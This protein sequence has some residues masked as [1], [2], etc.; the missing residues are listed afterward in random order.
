VRGLGLTVF[1]K[2]F[3]ERFFDVGIAEQ[4]AVTLA[5]GMACEGLKP[6]VA[7]YSSFLQRAYDQL[8]HDVCLQDLDVTFAVDRG[9]LVGADGATHAGSFDLSFGRP[10]PK[11]VIMAP[12]DE[13][14]CRAMLRTAY[15]YP[16]RRW[17]AIRAA[18]GR[19][20]RS[21]PTRRRSRSVGARWSGRVAGGPARL[22]QHGD[23]R[24]AAAEALG[25]TVAN[26]R[27][28]KP[29]DGRADPGAGR[30]P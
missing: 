7:I 2:R 4:H 3:P 16:G 18:A 23:A 15:E 30:G 6:V 25:A 24:L 5:A 20:W 28:V 29:L 10:L 12:A 9:G 17:C 1:S 14:E 26:M 21:T 22:R 11:L 8:I 13:N 27:F 19:A